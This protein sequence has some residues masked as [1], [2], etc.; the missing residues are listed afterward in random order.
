MCGGVGDVYKGQ[1]TAGVCVCVCVCV[2]CVVCV[3][4]WGGG[5]RSTKGWLHAP[6]V[7]DVEGAAGRGLP[8]S[9]AALGHHLERLL[10]NGRQASFRTA[11]ARGL[12]LPLI[13]I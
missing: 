12:H 1:H 13:H 9:L 4:V 2:W 5:H 6:V 3:C 8:A 10:P 7:G 11:A